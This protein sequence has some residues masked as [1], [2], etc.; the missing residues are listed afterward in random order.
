MQSTL[1]DRPLVVINCAVL[2]ESLLESELFGYEKG[3]FTGAVDAKPGLFEIADGG[4]LFID[5][6][7]ELACGL[8]AKLLRVLEDG[9]IRRNRATKERKVKVRLIAQPIEISARK[10]RQQVPGRSLLPSKR[11]IDHDSAIARTYR[12][13][14]SAHPPLAWRG[15]ET[16]SWCYGAVSFS[17][18]ARQYSSALNVLERVKS[19]RTITAS[20]SKPAKRNSTPV[21]IRSS[22]SL[23]W[24]TPK[25]AMLF[26]WNHFHNGT[27]PKCSNGIVA[28]KL[29]LPK[30]LALPVEASIPSSTI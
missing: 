19:Y 26:R 24:I 25:L 6:F 30:S 20:K 17:S 13:H 4:T 15:L 7:G 23:Y 28:I 2:P 8:Q 22:P 14:S 16:R 12:R 21:R 5:E 29:V 1:S 18:M 9:T 11:F 10:W 27:L 3:A